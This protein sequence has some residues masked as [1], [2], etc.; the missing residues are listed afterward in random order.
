MGVRYGKLC[1]VFKTLLQRHIKPS[2]QF[3]WVQVIKNRQS[4]ELVQARNHIP[5]FDVRQ[6]ADMQYKLPAAA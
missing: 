4:V 2:E 3:Q 5:V 6:A 1:P